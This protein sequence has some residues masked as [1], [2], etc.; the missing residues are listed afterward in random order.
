M[1]GMIP[2]NCILGAGNKEWVRTM[3]LIANQMIIEWCYKM[4][5]KI[6][7]KQ[8]LRKEKKQ[9]SQETGKKEQK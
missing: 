1:H 9:N 6:G 3:G 8:K 2:R 7:D 4:A 5:Q